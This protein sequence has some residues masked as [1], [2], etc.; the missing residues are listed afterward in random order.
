[1]PMAP[2]TRQ[3]WVNERST[4]LYCQC[5]ICQTDYLVNNG[6]TSFAT[7]PDVNDG[8]ADWERELLA[9]DPSLGGDSNMPQQRITYGVEIECSV[10]RDP[11]GRYST[12]D[13]VARGLQALGINA[14]VTGY[15]GRDYSRWQ[16]KSDVSLSASSGHGGTCEVVSPILTWGDDE[17]DRQLRVV[18]EFLTSIGAEANR[19]CGGHAHVYVGHLTGAQL[20]RL[21]TSYADEPNQRAIDN[22]IRRERQSS[23][24]HPYCRGISPNNL[25]YAVQGAEARD[26]YTMSS[27]LGGHSSNVNGDWYADRGTFEFRQRHGSTNWHK[28]K[29]WV[30]FL[31]ALIR[32]AEDGHDVNSSST[33]A[34]LDD[35]V[36]SE[37]LAPVLRQ[38]IVRGGA[39][40]VDTG[41]IATQVQA[42]QSA[43]RQRVSR[44]M[45]LQGVA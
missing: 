29:A 16:I 37:Y 8:L 31:V 20:G 18:S 10:P 7:F 27:Y 11:Q 25:W 19:S 43:A 9:N 28:W 1:M 34:M 36:A 38:W 3:Q 33:D 5:D 44:L 35:L 39:P 6:Y 30:G 24:N 4:G 26:W 23:A 13:Y 32:A 22:L 12:Q 21:I 15:S 14:E 41:D 17:S 45:R 42:A 2:L 40:R